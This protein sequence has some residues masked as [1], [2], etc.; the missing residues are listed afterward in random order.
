MKTYQIVLLILAGFLLFGGCSVIST[1][2]TVIGLEEN[3][4][5]SHSEIQVQEKREYDLITKLVQVV[6]EA[7][8]YEKNTLVDIVNARKA[9]TNNDVKSALTSINVIAEQYPNLKANDTYVQLMTELSVSENLK[10]QYR[11]SYNEFIKQYKQY[12][13]RFPNNIILSILGY[14]NQNYQYLEF[15]ETNLPVK[16]FDGE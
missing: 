10:T 9:V 13:K 14:E 12:V 1:N 4:E 7:T 8:K 11:L 15:E 6:E 3:I 5:Q 2:N 16:L